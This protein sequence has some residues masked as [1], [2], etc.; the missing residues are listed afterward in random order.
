LTTPLNTELQELNA[1]MTRLGSLVEHALSQVLAALEMGDRDKACAVVVGDT[2][3]DDL[4]LAIQQHA[5]RTLIFH[6]PLPGRHLRYLSS[7]VP[8]TND[9]ERIAD[10]A[11]GITQ[12]FLRMVP[13]HYAEVGAG[14]GGQ[15]GQLQETHDESRPTST[16][17]GVTQFPEKLL[18]RR[19]LDL[20]QEVQSLLQRTMKAFTDRDA[21]AARS[22]WQEDQV[23][24]K[25]HYLVSQD[26]LAMLEG[27]QAISALQRDPS[28]LQQVTYMLWIAYKFERMADHCT[29]I[30]E[31]IVFLV[32]G[33][34]DIYA[35]LA[36][37]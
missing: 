21:Q 7:L 34:T 29:N 25:G 5:F 1:Q 2:T 11:E 9:L 14:S 17:G 3:I 30:C 36:R 22:I 24:N 35:T 16:A 32:E 26:L 28:M 20:G 33:E 12:I 6:Q 13:Y 23:V 18:M 27:S 4:H 31:S 10:E 19:I 37:E 15:G 8:I